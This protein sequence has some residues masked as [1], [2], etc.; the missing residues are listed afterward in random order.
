MCRGPC[1][2]CIVKQILVAEYIQAFSMNLVCLSVRLIVCRWC[3]VCQVVERPVSFMART[4]R[5]RFP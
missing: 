1:L 5:A 2:P 3:S 4:A